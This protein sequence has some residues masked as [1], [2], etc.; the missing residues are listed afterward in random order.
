M[1]LLEAIV[2]LWDKAKMGQRKMEQDPPGVNL[3]HRLIFPLHVFFPW[4]NGL[5]MIFVFFLYL[6]GGM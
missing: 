1:D 3:Q 5:Q 6:G 2:N 4:P